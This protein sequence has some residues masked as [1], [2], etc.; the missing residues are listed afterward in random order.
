MYNL[1]S[2]NF[3]TTHDCDKT[4]CDFSMDISFFAYLYTF[5]LGVGCFSFINPGFVMTSSFRLVFLFTK[6][7]IAGYGAYGEYIYKPYKKYLHRPLMRLCNLNDGINEIKIVKNGVI[8]YEFKTMQDFI[9]NNPIKFIKASG[10][11]SDSDSEQEEEEEEE[12]TSKSECHDNDKQTNEIGTMDMDMDIDTVDTIIDAD[13]TN[14]HINV[15]E[16][17]SDHNTDDMGDT[18]EDEDED[19]G[20]GEDESEDYILNPTEY[21][22]VL[23]TFYSENKDTG[24]MKGV[25]LKYNTFRKSEL[26]VVYIPENEMSK[27]KFIGINLKI[28]DKKYNINLND[29]INYYV[30]GNTIL[31]FLF[32]KWYMAYHYDV[33]LTLTTKYSVS[34]I[35]NRIEMY[36]IQPGKKI[37]IETNKFQIEDDESFNEYQKSEKKS[38]SES[39]S[40]SNNEL[41]DTPNCET[42]L[43]STACVSDNTNATDIDTISTEIND[44]CDIEILDYDCGCD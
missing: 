44:I 43:S 37:Y 31:D 33:I 32:L 25:C 38:E 16:K 29:P 30:I 22:F 21:D 24:D 1:Q 6:L 11:D 35:D 34:C 9:A 23:R 17:E 39:E 19:D 4:D 36:T 27:R 15:H 5:L 7:M 10:S 18:N 14:A 3:S 12:E 13:L 28:D 41:G 26:K 40:E 8:I 20:K 42:A 2:Q